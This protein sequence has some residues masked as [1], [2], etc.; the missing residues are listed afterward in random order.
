[1]K[2]LIVNPGS[3]ST[4]IGIFED[5]NLILEKVLRHQTE[6]LKKFSKIT[7]QYSFRLGFIE[8]ALKEANLEIADF[9]GVVGMGG[10]LKPISGGTYIVNQKLVD[11]LSSG[12]YG[13]HASNL[14]GIIAYALGQKIGKPSFIV[15]PVVVDE[16]NDVAR[17]SGHPKIKRRSI[18]HALNQKAIARLHCDKIGKQ[19]D[20]VT[21]IVAHMGG[22]ISIGLHKNGR[23]VDANNALDGEGPFTPERSGSLPVGDLVTLC[24]SGVA[25][26]E[27]KKMI[28][29]NGGFTA[30]FGTNNMIEIAERAKNEPEVGLVFDAFT[31][32]IAK[33]IAALSTVACGKVNA[34]LLTGGIVYNPDIVNKIRERVGFI[35]PVI[36]YPG[37][38]E[39]KA[40]AQG[41]LRV[42]KGE[43]EGKVYN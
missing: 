43:E 29:G 37:E 14:G 6:E 10:L 39:L 16:F 35:A 34:I 5:E 7:D 9:D 13:E 17:I 15:D 4:K 42:L 31:Y 20:E 24:Y 22:G 23:V 3:T 1:M 26:S 30:Y 28:V 33:E 40:L 38:D 18:F 36:A 25:Q 32:Q 2:L 8:E 27:I 21:F 41:A 19:Y 12:S 11:D